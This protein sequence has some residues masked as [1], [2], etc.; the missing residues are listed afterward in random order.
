MCTNITMAMAIPNKPAAHYICSG[1]EKKASKKLCCVSSVVVGGLRCSAH[2][3][4]N[5][6]TTVTRPERRSG[7]YGPSLWDFDYIQSMSSD[8]YTVRT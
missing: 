6:D 3:K 2:N 4:P 8:E 1:F 7:N 5:C